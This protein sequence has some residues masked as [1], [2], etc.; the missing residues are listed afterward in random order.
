M[1]R[2]HHNTNADVAYCYRP[3]CVIC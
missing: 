1:I 3:S 2:W